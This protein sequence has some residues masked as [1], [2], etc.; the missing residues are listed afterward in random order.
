MKL[1][2]DIAATD[3]TR[4]AV[5]SATN[6][7][8]INVS[9]L[10]LGDI[11]PMD[12]TFV[13]SSATPPGAP[14]WAG[15]A[16]YVLSLGF[17]TLDANTF[18]CYTSVNSTAAKT[19]GWTADL[20]LN[21]DPL[22]QAV[23]MGVST[24]GGWQNIATDPRS[25]NQRPMW[26]YFW[27]QVQVLT[28]AMEP[29]TYAMIRVAMV[30]RVLPA[31][32]Q[33]T[34]SAESA[35]LAWIGA[36]AVRNAASLTGLASAVQD[37]T[38]LGGNAAGTAGNAVGTVLVANFSA[39]I[40]D[41]AGTHAGTLTMLYQVQRSTSNAAPLWVRPYNYDGASN[42]VAYRLIAAF[43]D[44]LPAAYNATTGNFHY[45]GVSGAAGAVYTFAD[46][47]GTAAPA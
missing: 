12:V 7:V 15:A 23:L 1:V 39:V 43:L 25:R 38:K 18:L 31:S 21:T 24:G 32:V 11:E 10:V 9:Q 3:K 34:A 14:S 30:N 29:V 22:K 8:P 5:Q 33:S 2:I 27:L 28:P 42:A 36:N 13:D 26:A 40:N 45:M 20:P 17:G 19:G 44:T 6:P 37:A 16:G 47:T 4:A 46:Q 41:G 35:L